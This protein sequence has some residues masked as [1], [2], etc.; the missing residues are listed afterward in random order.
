MAD[1]IK[2]TINKDSGTVD[3]TIRS[4]DVKSETFRVSVSDFEVA[5]A[6]YKSQKK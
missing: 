3:I 6:N 2:I 5:L 1:I 4:S